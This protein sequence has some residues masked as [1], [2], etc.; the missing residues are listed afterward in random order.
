M[1]QDDFSEQLI[2]V[3][4]KFKNIVLV[5][6]RFVCS[7]GNNFLEKF[8]KIKIEYDDLLNYEKNI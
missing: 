4:D 7:V 1:N 5:D 3:N 8:E 2:P 6:E